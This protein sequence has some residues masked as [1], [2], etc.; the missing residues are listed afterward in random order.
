MLST[1]SQIDVVILEYSIRRSHAG[2]VKGAR[3]RVILNR[4]IFETT[5]VEFK[6]VFEHF[7]FPE[8]LI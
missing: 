4:E 7:C 1:R 6:I 3:K 5:K 2:V 8:N